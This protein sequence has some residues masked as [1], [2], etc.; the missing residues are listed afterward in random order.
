ERR[1]LLITFGRLPDNP[2]N[3]ARQPGRIAVGRI[4]PTLAPETRLMGTQA[5]LRRAIEDAIAEDFDDLA[6][7]AAYAD[8]LTEQGDPRGEFV[9]AQLDA[10]TL[11]LPEPQRQRAWERAGQLRQSHERAWLGGL[12]KVLLD[13][14]EP[15]DDWT[16]AVSY[17][18]EFRRG[19]L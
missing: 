15:L 6:S 7:H 1:G 3:Y 17:A 13:Q 11:S 2:R 19:W 12:A 10:E 4:L 5:A 16:G 9:R 18:H 8:L 14:N